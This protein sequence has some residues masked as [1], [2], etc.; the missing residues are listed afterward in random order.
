MPS[1]I[2]GIQPYTVILPA[3]SA[4]EGRSAATKDLHFSFS[5]IPPVPSVGGSHGMLSM[6][7]ACSGDFF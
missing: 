6:P 3:P 1:A 5:V 4:V 2:T 7:W